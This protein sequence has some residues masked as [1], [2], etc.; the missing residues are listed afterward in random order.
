M[1]ILG[2]ERHAYAPELNK[3][4][5]K[6]GVTIPAPYCTSVSD[7]RKKLFPQKVK[8]LCCVVRSVYPEEWESLNKIVASGRTKSRLHAYK[9]AKKYQEK[10][11]VLLSGESLPPNRLSFEFFY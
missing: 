11:G 5:L 3:L 2:L 9:F 10:G 4:H 6:N 1:K 7:A 8:T